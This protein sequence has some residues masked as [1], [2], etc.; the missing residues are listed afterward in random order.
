ME[1]G[2]FT[3]GDDLSNPCGQQP[4]CVLGRVQS[5]ATIRHVWENLAHSEALNHPQKAGKELPH[6]ELPQDSRT[7]HR[8]D[9]VLTWAFLS[10]LSGEWESQT[11]I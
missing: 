9:S 1:N 5:L 6:G 8:V 11:V 10:M 4:H 7:N 2:P 3:D